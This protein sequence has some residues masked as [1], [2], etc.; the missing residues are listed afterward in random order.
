[1]TI[2]NQIKKRIGEI[3]Q[4]AFFFN[5]NYKTNAVFVPLDITPEELNVAYEGNAKKSRTENDI[6]QQYAEM[7]KGITQSFEIGEYKIS[8]KLRAVGS[9][10][11]IHTN[12][13]DL[14]VENNNF[15]I[16]NKDKLVDKNIVYLIDPNEH[17]QNLYE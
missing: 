15:F 10:Y 11:G 7:L 2:D 6:I 5:D 13:F 17:L 16:Q 14:L 3:N 9:V 1:M 12:N 8:I 4:N